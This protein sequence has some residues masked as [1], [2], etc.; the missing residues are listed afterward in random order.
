MGGKSAFLLMVALLVLTGLACG[1][2]GMGTA[3]TPPTP[4][5]TGDLF[6]LNIPA[7]TYNL[8]PGENVPGTGLVY[9]G[10]REETFEVSMDNQITLKRPGDSFYWSGVLAP[11]VLANYNLRLTT[12]VFGSMPVAG[13][14]EIII[15]NPEPVEELGVP[16]SVDRLRFSNAVIDYTVPPGSIVPGTTLRFE[17][18]EARGQGGQTTNFAR[19]SGGN[20]Y[21]Y[22]ALGDSLVWTGR[23]RDNVHIAYNLRVTSLSER[24]VRLSGVAELWVDSLR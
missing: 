9:L 10:R 2:P 12:P 14:V 13:P 18:I 4:T 24:G 6:I 11:G 16:S 20:I 23:L 15:L 3:V 21:P 7:F 8:A 19:L 1:V 22:L 5:P 17:G